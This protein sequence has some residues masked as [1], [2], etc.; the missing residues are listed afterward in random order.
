[1]PVSSDCSHFWTRSTTLRLVPL[2]SL[3]E[4]QLPVGLGHASQQVSMKWGGQRGVMLL[5]PICLCRRA[6]DAY[7]SDDTV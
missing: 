5:A 2:C 7:Y 3:A 6:L 1:M 4:G